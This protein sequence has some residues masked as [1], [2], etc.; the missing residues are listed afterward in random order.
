MRVLLI[1]PKDADFARVGNVVREYVKHHAG[2]IE[3]SR[4]HGV[5]YAGTGKAIYVW[6]SKTQ[7]TLHFGDE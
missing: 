7:I 4:R 3:R 6:H 5:I 2:E 1:N